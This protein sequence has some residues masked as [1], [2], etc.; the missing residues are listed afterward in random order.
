MAVRAIAIE[1]RQ[2]NTLDT[3]RPAL[4][5]GEATDSTMEMWPTRPV[6]PSDRGRRT[7]DRKTSAA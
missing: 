6:A 4:K 7:V 1:I 3:A 2:T 5:H